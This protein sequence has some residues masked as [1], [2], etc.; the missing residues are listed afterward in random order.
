MKQ[1]LFLIVSNGIDGRA[2]TQIDHAFTDEQERDR[3]HNGMG[4]N[5]NYYRTEDR[6]IDLQAHS[7]EV[8]KRLDGLDKLALTTHFGATFGDQ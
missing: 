6:V 7:K 4:K 8:I 1:A 3:F 5:K 2:K